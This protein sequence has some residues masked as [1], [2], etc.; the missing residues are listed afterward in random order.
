[1]MSFADNIVSITYN[2]HKGN[3]DP[4]C[5]IIEL[6]TKDII[7]VHIPV[8]LYPKSKSMRC[9]I[10]CKYFNNKGKGK[11]GYIIAFGESYMGIPR[12]NECDHKDYKLCQS[13]ACSCFMYPCI[14]SYIAEKIII[15][16]EFITI[17]DFPMDIYKHMLSIAVNLT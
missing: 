17:M 9:Y 12:C 14:L 7:I 5:I 13:K 6:Y 15:F 10:C 16:K 3:I 2:K 8:Y 4:S 1:M 11:P